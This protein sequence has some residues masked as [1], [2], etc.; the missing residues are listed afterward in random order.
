MLFEINLEASEEVARQIRLRNLSGLIVIDFIDMQNPVYSIKKVEEILTEA[1]KK[2]R[3][4]HTIMPIS[5]LGLLEISRQRIGKTLVT[6]S[7]EI[8]YL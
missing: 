6:S 4:K 2:D 7:M 8:F 3:S 5:E 1:M